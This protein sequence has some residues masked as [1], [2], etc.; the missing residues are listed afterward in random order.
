MALRIITQK[1]LKYFKGIRDDLRDDLPFEKIKE[2]VQ[3]RK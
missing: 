3:M 2:Y 1:P